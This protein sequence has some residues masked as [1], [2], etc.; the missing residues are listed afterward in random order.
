[1]VIIDSDLIPDN[2]EVNDSDNLQFPKETN[3]SL[4]RTKQKSIE[5]PSKVNLFF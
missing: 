1:M 3:S 4:S 2:H 5:L